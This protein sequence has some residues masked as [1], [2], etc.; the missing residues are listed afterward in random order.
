DLGF[1]MFKNLLL[2]SEVWQKNSKL[3]SYRWNEGIGVDS[4]S[5]KYWG[6]FDKKEILCGFQQKLNIGKIETGY[7][8]S[9]AK[10][11]NMLS[12]SLE[13][14]TQQ[15]KLFIKLLIQL[16][17]KLNLGQEMFYSHHNYSKNFKISEKYL[18]YYDI[19]AWYLKEYTYDVVISSQQYSCPE[20]DLKF[21][22]YFVYKD[23]PTMYGRLS[24]SM[25]NAEKD[26]IMNDNINY[27]ETVAEFCHKIYKTMYF[28]LIPRCTIFNKKYFVSYF[29]GLN[30]V[31]PAAG[32]I[33][34]GSGYLLPYGYNEDIGLFV[35]ARNEKLYN[36]LA[37]TGKISEA[38][39]KFIEEEFC[40]L[41]LK[42]Q[43]RF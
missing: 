5:K 38:E 10:Y 29:A 16:T 30:F 42:F 27:Y 31:F 18:N 8:Y 14:N 13:Q 1:S 25:Y 11:Y 21:Q 43:L 12:K 37:A 35:D 7:G 39:R 28:Q 2:F 32:F 9:T 6:L 3:Q 26:I 36:F 20:K 41:L 4:P 33:S 40:P 19:P 24:F 34:I 23:L 15:N 17:K 22:L